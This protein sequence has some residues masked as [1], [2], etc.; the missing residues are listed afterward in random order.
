MSTI[1]W[2]FNVA[3]EKLAEFLPTRW[4]HVQGV[5]RQAQTLRPISGADSDLLEA[6]AVLHDVGYAPDL[7]RTGFHP[8]DGAYFLQDVGA[9]ARLVHLVAHHSCAAH[10]AAL[11]GLSREIDRF[12]DERGSIRDG[13]WFC[14]LTTAPDGQEVDARARME[15]IKERYGAGHL[16]TRFITEAR[17]ELLGAVDRTRSRLEAVSHPK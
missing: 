5:A 4:A 12:D 13:L 17:D 1:E 9:P 8:L 10:E 7:V 14:D 11:R 16:V 2:A 6:A 15:E 3:Q